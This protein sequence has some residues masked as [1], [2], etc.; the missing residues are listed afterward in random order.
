MLQD[1]TDDQVG[2]LVFGGPATRHEVDRSVRL[3]KMIFSVH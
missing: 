3:A 1:R 2:S